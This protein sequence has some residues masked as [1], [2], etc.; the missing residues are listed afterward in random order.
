M[1]LPRGTQ[2][3][4]I[5]IEMH[6][7]GAFIKMPNSNNKKQLMIRKT[8]SG[9]SLKQ[10]NVLLAKQKTAHSNPKLFRFS[11]FFPLICLFLYRLYV[12]ILFRLKNY[13]HLKIYL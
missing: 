12:F 7:S 11:N 5:N 6:F 8:L 9:S 4:A 10:T 2:T 3:R 13:T 1:L